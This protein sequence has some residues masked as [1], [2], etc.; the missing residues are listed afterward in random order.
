MPQSRQSLNGLFH[1]GIFDINI[2][3]RTGLAEKNTQIA[4]ATVYSSATAV[5]GMIT[6]LS[7]PL[8]C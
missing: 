8:R 5:G 3:I 2:R 6:L 7:H 4:Q 1:R